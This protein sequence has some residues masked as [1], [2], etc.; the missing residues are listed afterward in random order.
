MVGQNRPTDG[1]TVLYESLCVTKSEVKIDRFHPANVV[2]WVPRGVAVP[3]LMAADLL[4][5][6]RD[7][8]HQVRATAT[9]LIHSYGIMEYRSLVG[10]KFTTMSVET[11]A[12]D[13]DD[14]SEGLDSTASAF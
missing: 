13:E 1:C 7:S 9:G 4:P 11:V 12:I 2:H 14:E 5:F 10:R 6:V 8:E 3:P